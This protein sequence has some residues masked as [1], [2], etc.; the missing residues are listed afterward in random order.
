MKHDGK[1]EHYFSICRWWRNVFVVIVQIV[2]SIV[3]KYCVNDHHI[4]LIV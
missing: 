1:I 4:Y 3:G 2:M